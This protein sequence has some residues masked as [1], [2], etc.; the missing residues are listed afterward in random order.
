M[1]FEQR[2]EV[3]HLFS[4]VFYLEILNGVIVTKIEQ[5]VNHEAKDIIDVILNIN[6]YNA[7]I[8]NKNISSGLD[9]TVNDTIYAY[10]KITNLIF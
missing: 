3:F 8:S 9:S 2:L 6:Q 5:K 4:L 1:K 7:I 10:Q